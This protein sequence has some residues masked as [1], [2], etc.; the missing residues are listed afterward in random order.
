MSEYS[1]IYLKSEEADIQIKE[2]LYEFERIKKAYRGGLIAK[3]ELIG[4]V[5]QSISKVFEVCFEKNG[6]IFTMDTKQNW[7]RFK[8]EYDLFSLGKLCSSKNGSVWLSYRHNEEASYEDKSQWFRI[9]EAMHLP[10]DYFKPVDAY[11][12]NDIPRPDKTDVHYYH[13]CTVKS[14][15]FDCVDDGGLLTDK[16]PIGKTYVL[17]SNKGLSANITVK[18]YAK[19]SSK[20]CGFVCEGWIEGYTAKLPRKMPEI[21]VYLNKENH[22]DY[23]SFY[24]SWED[25]KVYNDFPL[26]QEYFKKDD[27]KEERRIDCIKSCID[28]FKLNTLTD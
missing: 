15:L 5:Y 19:V 17:K 22:I 14:I 8:E 24:S 28:F 11:I 26:W 21:S 1:K 9:V 20:I 18:E 7:I 23:M 13:N 27:E 25:Q 16:N 2:L 10:I 3:N 12:D 6:L 4:F